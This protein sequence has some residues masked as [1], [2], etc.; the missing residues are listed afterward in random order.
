MLDSIVLK[1]YSFLRQPLMVSA[2][3]AQPNRAEPTNAEKMRL[4][5]WSYIRNAMNT[6][7]TQFTFFGPG[8]ILFLSELNL[9]KSQIGL[10]LSFFPFLGA[11]SLIL[12][13]SVGRLGYKKTWLAFYSTRKLVTLLL[14]L[15]PWVAMKRGA[16]FTLFYV[17]AIVLLVGLCRAISETAIYPWLQEIVPNSIRGR[18]SAVNNIVINIVGVIAVTIASWVLEHG[19]GLSRFT[20]LFAVGIFFGLLSV[21][22]SWYHPGGASTRGTDAENISMGDLFRVLRDSTFVRFVAGLG[23]VTLATAPM[24]SFLPLYMRQQIG[25]S[26]GNVVMLQNGTLIGALSA[27]YLAGWASDRY[28]SKPV[29]L[30]GLWVMMLLPIG[31]LIMPRH[32]FASLPVA[33]SIAFLQ[34]IGT[35]MWGIGSSRMLYVSIVPN[36]NALNTWAFII[37]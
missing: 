16:D 26:D 31:W 24:F 25:L 36:D 17:G 10:L 18:Y 4:L 13:P 9:N 30:S 2:N 3:I 19:E 11:V 20:W 23:M 1:T 37:R 6:V 27:T 21:W 14:L 5:H 7:Y 8:F 15:T 12:T 28:G 35:I 22:A 33:V 34:G 29:M 32:T